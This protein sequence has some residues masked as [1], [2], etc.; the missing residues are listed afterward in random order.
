MKKKPISLYLGCVFV[1]MIWVVSLTPKSLEAVSNPWMIPATVMRGTEETLSQLI[2]PR[3]DGQ[4]EISERIGGVMR[5]Y[6]P[7][8]ETYHPD[9][10]QWQGLPSM[11]RVGDRLWAAWYSGGT[12]EP[13]QFNYLIVAYSDDFGETWVDPFLILDHPD[14]GQTGVS[15]VVP[16]LWVDEEGRLVLFWIQYHTWILRFND[17]GHPDID[18]V[19]WD[20]PTIYTSSKIHKPPTPFIDEDGS[21]GLILASEAEAGDTHIEITRF[22]VSKDAGAS[23]S[24]RSN[25][26]S[27][28]PNNRR[29]PESQ[30][31]Q[32]SDG[33]LLVMSR[34]EQGNG[35]GIE[36]ARSTDFGQS[37]SP[38]QNNLE[39]PFIGPG[40]KFHIMTL[41][42][43]NLLVINHNTTSSRA[44]LVAYLS[45]D[46]GETFPYTLPIDLRTDV[47]YPY[48]YQDEAGLIY[49]TW[50]KGRFHEKEIRYAI[51]TEEDL[52]AGQYHS[53]SAVELGIISK[54][55]P[56]F[57]EIVAIEEAFPTTLTHPV[58]TPSATI[59]DTL[60]TT[61]VVTDNQGNSHTLTG[62][63]R[64]PGYLQDVPGTYRLHFQTA[65]PAQVA[66]TYS[67]LS[68]T[69]ELVETDS[70]TPWW[71][72]ALPLGLVVMLGGVGLVMVKGRQAVK[73]A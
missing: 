37:F 73:G 54:L 25:L 17:A 58:G 18:Q 39:P 28:S 31:A 49:A 4:T 13:R 10:R 34:L 63:W 35:G 5:T 53:E 66:D 15:L 43:G 21:E 8:R 59:R 67:L 42:S 48:A 52:L 26:P 27:S 64:S 72:F 7:K 55:N 3:A 50:D 24:L 71:W 30:I 33:S 38:Y 11:V 70:T 62:T 44:G 23:W 65:L 22:Y 20:E 56:D 16:N 9:D 47:T 2:D 68:M 36:V 14:P 1:L 19:T 45:K 60:P 61:I 32:T 12:G 40:S 57:K 46:N 29:W 6:T 69:V 51:F 41:A